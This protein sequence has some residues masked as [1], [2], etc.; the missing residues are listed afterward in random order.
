ML[1]WDKEREML[2]VVSFEMSGTFG[3]T[4]LSGLVEV[5]C[6]VWERLC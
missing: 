2:Y 4:L 3:M 1:L 6:A 5:T